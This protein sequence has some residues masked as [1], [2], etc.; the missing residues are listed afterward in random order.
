MTWNSLTFEVSSASER[1]HRPTSESVWWQL[2]T[3]TNPDLT[4]AEVWGAL[5]GRLLSFTPVCSLYPLT[6]IGQTW[7]TMTPRTQKGM[8]YKGW[9]HNTVSFLKETSV[10]KSFY[11]IYLFLFLSSVCDF[12]CMHM[13]RV[14][15]GVEVKRQRARNRSLLP[16]HGFWEANSCC[17]ACW[18]APLPTEPSHQLLKA[19]FSS[20]VICPTAPK[21]QGGKMFEVLVIRDSCA[22]RP[23]LHSSPSKTI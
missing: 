14:E 19:F 23:H 9:R 13:Y 5:P 17:Q 11:F 4:A 21:M 6:I 1:C 2:H 22:L 18:Q 16:P 12:E 15:V 20:A 10:N 3:R 8:K 7:G